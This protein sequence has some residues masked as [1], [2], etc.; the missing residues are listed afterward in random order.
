MSEDTDGTVV[1]I[2][3]A[4][5]ETVNADALGNYGLIPQDALNEMIH[6]IGNEILMDTATWFGQEHAVSLTELSMG[7][8]AESGEQLDEVR[9]L[10][11]DDADF[12]DPERRS[13]YVKEFMDVFYYWAALAALLRI[14]VEQCYVMLREENQERYG[15]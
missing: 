10:M 15:K 12:N 9:R 2:G 4:E 1:P 5:D 6:G 14:D 13:K 3:T 8:A 7:L 11:R